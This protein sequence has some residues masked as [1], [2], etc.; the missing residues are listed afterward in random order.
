LNEKFRG[1]EEM[2]VFWD[3]FYADLLTGILNT[4]FFWT[5]PVVLFFILRRIFRKQWRKIERIIK[6]IVVMK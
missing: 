3:V 2:S 6:K 4:L 5:F 1:G